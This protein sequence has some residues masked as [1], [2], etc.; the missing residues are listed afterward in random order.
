MIATTNNQTLKDLY[1]SMYT[2][3][4]ELLNDFTDECMFDT[5]QKRT[6]IFQ[7]INNRNKSLKSNSS[8]VLDNETKFIMAKLIKIDE[9]MTKKIQDRLNQIRAEMNGLYSKSRATIAYTS[10]KKS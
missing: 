1:Q 6:E 7:E 2:I 10:Y 4:S 9:L 3:S 5:I 8:Q